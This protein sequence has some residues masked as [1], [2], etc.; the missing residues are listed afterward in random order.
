MHT[1]DSSTEFQKEHPFKD[2]ISPLR[3]RS[4]IEQAVEKLSQ[5][6]KTAPQN[7]LDAFSNLASAMSE[8]E[9]KAQFDESINVGNPC[10]KVVCYD[11][12]GKWLSTSLINDATGQPIPHVS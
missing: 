12:D 7:V 5:F 4:T 10:M 2:F 1:T 8:K 11:K 9:N 6:H 3:E